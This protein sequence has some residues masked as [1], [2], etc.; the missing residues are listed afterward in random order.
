MV[1]DLHELFGA[2]L[3]EARA[4]RWPSARYA[5]EP[6]RFCEEVLGFEPWS[7]QIE[8]L[9][10]LAGHQRVAVLSGQKT[11]KTRI[12]AAAALWFYATVP[13]GRVFLSAPRAPQIQDIIWPEVSVLHRQSGRCLVCRTEVSDGPRPCQHSAPLDGELSTLATTGLRGTDDGRVIHAITAKTLEALAGY[14]GPQLWIVDECSGV[15]DHVFD[16]IDGNGL[17]GGLK[18]LMLGNPTRNRGR[19]F[20]IFNSPKRAKA[21]ARVQMSSEEAAA[22]RDRRGEPFGHLA[23]QAEIEERRE[24]WGEDSALYLV[25]VKGQYALNEDGAVF[26]VVAISEA[27]E[28]WADDLGDGRLFIGVDPAGG[29]GFGD[30]SVFALRRGTKCLGL[31]ARRGLSEDAHLREILDLVEEYKRDRE[32]P[33]VVVDREGSIGS[34]LHARIVE[35]LDRFRGPGQRAPFEYV[36]VK[37]SAQAERMPQAYPRVRDELI[38]NLERWFRTGSIPDDDRLAKELS[39]VSWVEQVDQRLKATPKDEL[40]KQLDRSPDR[41]DALAL[42]CWESISLRLQPGDALPPSAQRALERD[43]RTL[44]ARHAVAGDPVDARLSPAE[45][46]TIE[47][48][49]Y[50]RGR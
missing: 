41:M 10:A 8:I 14:S 20:E 2:L 42:A 33:V 46:R 12:A 4:V 34:V 26:S 39:A 6:V 17:G 47:R 23:K 22:A 11:G 24:L 16:V 43:R 32:Q 48:E 3:E 37:A 49:I 5:H 50:R 19:M 9:R 27:I 15:D 7:R 40:R 44:A 28:R 18:V 35:Y 1:A 30:E 38:A 13:G 25:R 31:V 45:R 21:Y 29:S 36:P